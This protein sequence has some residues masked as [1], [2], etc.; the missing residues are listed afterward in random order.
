MVPRKNKKTKE[1]ELVPAHSLKGYFCGF[2]Q[3]GTVEWCP[4][5]RTIG[6]EANSVATSNTSDSG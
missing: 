5:R 1:Y 3:G 6:V 2:E 4:K